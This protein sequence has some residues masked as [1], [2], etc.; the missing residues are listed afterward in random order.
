[1]NA[2][3]YLHRAH[4][5][6]KRL[7]DGENRAAAAMACGF[8]TGSVAKAVWLAKIFTPT[9]CAELGVETLRELSASHL[10]PVAT[11]P[12]QARTRLL[13]LAAKERMTVRE[14][15]F[16]AAQTGSPGMSSAA[17]VMGGETQFKGVAMALGMYADWSD[18]SLERVL[19]GPC[20]ALI[21]EVAEHGAR[22]L[23][24]IETN[25]EAA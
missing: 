13:R 10:E 20:G 18:E 12:E 6:E 11:L 22:L 1:M 2:R 24:R 21:R 9:V 23:R 16:A 7:R 3:E 19:R 8:A 15:K 4:E 25:C 14:L 17:A 5:L